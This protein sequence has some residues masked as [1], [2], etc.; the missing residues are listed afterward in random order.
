MREH[1]SGSTFP[2][3]IRLFRFEIVEFGLTG[4]IPLSKVD[5]LRPLL[6]RY[7]HRLT[8]STNLREIIPAVLEKEKEKLR[9]ELET[10]KE[11]GVIF[12]GTARM[13]EALAIVIRFEQ[14]D[15]KLTQR[16]IQFELLALRH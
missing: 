8:H 7:G 13:G 15:F 12:D 14:E 2:A 16:L 5:F 10:V 11:A 3:D 9:S 6:E 1:P 4:G